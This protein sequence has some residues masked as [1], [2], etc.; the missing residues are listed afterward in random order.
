MPNRS[1]IPANDWATKA[2][3]VQSVFT[4][5]ATRKARPSM[6]PENSCAGLTRRANGSI[7]ASSASQRAGTCSATRSRSAGA[8]ASMARSPPSFSSTAGAAPRRSR[9]FP[10]HGGHSRAAAETA[11]WRDCSLSLALARRVKS[12]FRLSGG[13][14]RKLLSAMFEHSGAGFP[15]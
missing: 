3:W 13:K 2:S 4:S 10:R 15:L 1:A 5:L 14:S 7:I 6:A 12:Q 9:S 11:P 8:A